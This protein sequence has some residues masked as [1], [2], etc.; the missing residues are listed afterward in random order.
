MKRGGLG[1]TTYPIRYGILLFI[2][3]SC[4]Y[5][6]FTFAQHQDSIQYDGNTQLYTIYQ[7]D[8]IGEW[9]PAL[10]LPLKAYLQYSLR[11]DRSVWRYSATH[12]SK[13]NEIKKGLQL[14]T[15]GNIRLKLNFRDIQDDNPLLLSDLRRRKQ[16]E[17]SQES[18][19]NAVASYGE[20]LKL[21][22]QYNTL[23]SRI[24]EQKKVQFHYQGETY[25]LIQNIEVG[26]ITFQSQNPLI[27]LGTELFGA[28]GDFLFGPLA[29]TTIASREHD[30]ERRFTI[31][32]G[33]EVQKFEYRSSQYE[34]GKHF[35]LHKR[36][37]DLYNKA[38]EH[39]PLINST[40]QIDRIEVWVTRNNDM[41]YSREETILVDS[42]L[43]LGEKN[44]GGVTTLPRAELLSPEAYKVHPQLGFISLKEPLANNQELAVAFEYHLDGVRYQIGSFI[45]ESEYPLGALL[46]SENKEPLTPLWD[47]M[48]QN[49]YPLPYTT[50][51]LSPSTL[52]VQ[53]LFENLQTG[54]TEPHNREGKSWLHLF[55][56]DKSNASLSSNKPDGEIDNLP[57]T[58]F[59][60]F[61]G[62]LF[63][64]QRTPFA[65]F[66][67]N[68]YKKTPYA[69]QQ[70]K[71]KD[72]FLISGEIEGHSQQEVFLGATNLKE[73]SVI[74]RRGGQLLVEGVDYKVDYLTGKL[75]LTTSS[76]SS[77]IEIT[78]R[79]QEQVRFKEKSLFGLEANLSLLPSL[80]LGA[81]L[82][83]YTESSDRHQIRLGE[84]LLRNTLWGGHLSY[85]DTYQKEKLFLDK[86]WGETLKQP[87]EFDLQ[88]SYAQLDSRYN[89]AKSG[90]EEILLDNFD[91][92]GSSI[93]LTEAHKWHLSTNPYATDQNDSTNDNR[94][95]F[96][97]FEIDPILVRDGM[98]NQPS[99]L[100][101]SA[102]RQS[103]WV[104]EVQSQE[105]FPQR[106]VPST[107]YNMIPVLNLSFY[108]KERGPYNASPKTLTPKGELIAPRNGWGSIVRRIERTDFESEQFIYL[109]GWILN[110][111]FLDKTAPSG[112]ITFDL[113]DVSEDL[114]PDGE[115]GYESAQPYKE[116][117]F[118]KVPLFPP[119]GYAFDYTKADHLKDQDKGL[120]G[121]TSIEEQK[122]PY[123]D[124][125]KESEDP[126]NDD[127]HY[128]LGQ[129]YDLKRTPIL[130]R[131][132]HIN[133]TENNSLDNTIQG[134]PSAYTLFPDVE[135]VDRNLQLNKKESYFRYT[136]HCSPNTFKV[137]GH[138][139]VVAERNYEV[140]YN[141]KRERIQWLKLRIP[142][143]EA[144][145][146][147]GHPTWQQVRFI[148]LGVTQFNETIHF[149][150]ANLQIVS[151]HWQRLHSPEIKHP[152][153]ISRLSIQ[154]D[155]SRTPIPYVSPPESKREEQQLY[156]NKILQNEQ[157]LSLAFKN[158][159]EDETIATYSLTKWDLRHY[160][161][162]QL[163][164]HLHTTKES[165]KRG[166]LELFIRLGSDFTE[167][168]YEVVHPLTPTQIEDYST[169]SAALLANI[170]WQRDNEL[171]IPL[172]ELPVLKRERDLL[173]KGNSHLFRK[174]RFAVK[175]HPSLGNI[176][177]VVIG[178]RSRISFPV[179]GEVWIND[180]R[181]SGVSALGG[182][183]MLANGRLQFSDLLTISTEYAYRGA[184]FGAINTNARNMHSLKDTKS[185]TIE[186]EMNLEKMI[187]SSRMVAPLIFSYTK[188][189]H[190]PL[191]NP[192][193][194]DLLSL[195]S[196]SSAPLKEQNRSL[197]WKLDHAHFREEPNKGNSP[198]ALENMSFSYELHKQT[199]ERP[200]LPQVYQRAMSSELLYQYQPNSRNYIRLLSI[201][202]REYQHH[203]LAPNEPL[204]IFA[205][206][207]WIRALQLRYQ[208]FPSFAVNFDTQTTALLD[209]HHN[210]QVTPNGYQLLN[211]DLFRSLS[212]LGET[213]KS[214][215]NLLIQC[216]LPP[217]TNKWLHPLQSTLTWS[218]NS[219]W[220]RGILLD[221]YQD[222]HVFH[223]K[224]NA[225]FSIGY[226]LSELITNKNYNPL[227]T[228]LF[229]TTFNHSSSLP[230]LSKKAGKVL[231]LLTLFQPTPLQLT[232]EQQLQRALRKNWINKNPIQE[233]RPSD[234][235][236]REMISRLTLF[237]LKGLT[238]ELSLLYS[239]Q[240]HATY[241]VKDGSKLHQNRTIRM[242]RIGLKGIIPPSSIDYTAT[243][244]AI[245]DDRLLSYFLKK[246]GVIFSSHLDSSGLPSLGNFL[247]NWST[248]LNLLTMLPIL[249]PYLQR[250]DVNHR[251]TGILEVPNYEGTSHQI[252]SVTLSDQL[253]PFLGI[254][255]KTHFGL[256]I[257]T[258]YNRRY[259]STLL[260]GSRRLLN[261]LEQ[262]IV[263]SLTFHHSFKAPFHIPLFP[264]A[265]HTIT[266]S[267]QQNY[268]QTSLKVHRLNERTTD[269]TRGIITQLWNGSVDYQ[270]SKMISIRGFL[271]EVRRTPLVTYNGY[272]YKE[273]NYGVMLVVQLTP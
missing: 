246:N 244:K 198:L 43:A 102:E 208:P 219:D 196:N 261:Q 138:P 177:I 10:V 197:H 271:E 1:V 77:T 70:E 29:L 190:S 214:E 14:R 32:G 206:W 232:G 236:Q 59:L 135:D 8:S 64:P 130:E 38:L 140:D 262:D 268:T 222:G 17:F 54:V 80:Q 45:G 270:L 151:S 256:A 186:G 199:H 221:G 125:F 162:L 169:T 207:E 92:D 209:D 76:A 123:Y 57:G 108:P 163:T 142:L 237:P 110:P 119:Q 266:I 225:N 203:S 185:T 193:Q 16:L 202:N 117:S 187:N 120:D 201:W 145:F 259:N 218:N 257:Q 161:K 30:N 2:W 245:E 230:H 97:W 68:L 37:A 188:E 21:K 41:V 128:F 39:L 265:T 252:R 160:D 31:K 182:K 62:T 174:G 180:L 154:E 155:A 104:R 13:R 227:G 272:P 81:S 213:E 101:N 60:P 228:F 103:P 168:Y 254:S 47:L 82:F 33:R 44:F 25:D 99:V 243:E 4:V 215:Q 89:A 132:K 63:L 23:T 48:M 27:T 67:P 109:E 74:L 7:R 175:G 224:S 148:R 210:E 171:D 164:S 248:S 75:K 192:F 172:Q 72:K 170:I 93:S 85:H 26:N 238:I 122:H 150:L 46:C 9:K 91:S 242:S 234:F 12:L 260:I 247:P 127:Y 56:L 96:A 79:E 49:A 235:S 152:V 239:Q 191:F 273:R 211:K 204:S 129:E 233:Q 143:Q 98:P 114:I 121:M 52:H 240:E 71:E 131:Y 253:N 95:L 231:G 61:G 181:V 178:V 73:G 22:L 156:L 184:G 167:N 226:N 124:F 55:G 34:F 111:Y 165:L 137:G 40:L 113:G 216:S 212:H 118:G 133:G 58:L 250:L 35:F 65:S 194:S 264:S 223:S 144:N 78:V 18:S 153:T 205:Q 5:P 263:S 100:K 94:A 249:S 20:R 200:D 147:K 51:P 173:K 116:T 217:F 11:K 28:R 255:M 141:G 139:F 3:T 251:Y 258:Q 66:F 166:D 105:L 159:P 69:A 157:A 267:L 149:R 83:N 241:Q 189:E 24:G 19:I 53:I 88:L 158:L 86:I 220:Q 176:T 229:H 87:I 15:T 42:L 6:L 115:L 36:F 50:S 134:S 106:S 195:L 183:A 269:T 90:S 136:L 146:K 179:S 112:V 107:G 126:A 84:E